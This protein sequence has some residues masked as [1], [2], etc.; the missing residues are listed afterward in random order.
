MKTSFEYDN[1]QALCIIEYKDHFF[2]GQAHCHPDDEDFMSEKTG[3]FI[4]ES[5]AHQKYLKFVKNCE[6]LP[7]LEALNHLKSTLAVQESD[8]PNYFSRRLN[9][10]IKNLEEDL[11]MCKRAIDNEQQYLHGYIKEKDKLYKR[12]RL[13]N[14]ATDN[15]N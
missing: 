14:G 4:A 13:K 8:T 3:C 2:V 11:I 1:G 10:E 7:K 5:R 6:I 15:S 9:S 12:I